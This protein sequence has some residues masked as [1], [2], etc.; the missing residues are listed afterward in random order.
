MGNSFDMSNHI[1]CQSCQWISC[2]KD[3]F[4]QCSTCRGYFCDDIDGCSDKC[5]CCSL[6]KDYASYCLQ[7]KPVNEC[8]GNRETRKIGWGC[9]NMVCPEH[10]SYSCN[11]CDAV[12]CTECVGFKSDHKVKCY[13]PKCY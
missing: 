6:C 3:D 9:E 12:I 7:C 13:F 4:S 5:N 8:E 1:T 2:E 10:S 11:Y